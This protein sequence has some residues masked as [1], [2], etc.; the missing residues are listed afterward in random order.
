MSA[1][2]VISPDGFDGAHLDSVGSATAT[3]CNAPRMIRLRQIVGQVMHPHQSVTQDLI[4]GLPDDLTDHQ[5][6]Q[7]IDLLEN[8]DSIFSRGPYDMGRTTL[9]EHTIDTGN[10]RPI[11]QGLRRH[12]SAHMDVIDRQVND[13]V[14]H[15]IMELAVGHRCN[16]S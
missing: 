13:M 4:H 12:P 1:V 2:E 14:R 11:R 16:R 8:Y 5:R 3:Q 9:V 7:V 10:Q 6:S 15:E